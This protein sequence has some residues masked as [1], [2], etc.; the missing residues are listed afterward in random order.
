[1]F[2]ND[3]SP[4]VFNSIANCLISFLRNFSML[5][6]FSSIALANAVLND[7]GFSLASTFSLLASDLASNKALSISS[8]LTFADFNASSNFASTALVAS[9]TVVLMIA[10]ASSSVCALFAFSK[11]CAFC[12]KFSIF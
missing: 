3:I 6:A 9:A 11:S 7:T 12:S 5:S 1:M 10:F 8:I 4:T 2:D